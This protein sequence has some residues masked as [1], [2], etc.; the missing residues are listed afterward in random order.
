MLNEDRSSLVAMALATCTRCNGTGVAQE[1][2]CSCVNRGVFRSVMNKFR[3][4]A[5][6]AHHL[7]PRSMERSGPQGKTPAGSKSSEY[8]ADVCIIAKRALTEADFRLFQFHYLQGADWK[9]CCQRLGMSRG[10]FFHVCY[11]TEETLGRVFRELKPYPLYPLDEY[12]QA[13]TRTVDA[14]PFP[15][16]AERYP[17]G[18]PTQPPLAM[19]GPQARP[20]PVPVLCKPEPVRAPVAVT[21]DIRDPAEIAAH[22]RKL[23]HLGKPLCNIAAQLHRLGVPPAYGK[24]EWRPCDVKTILLFAPRPQLRKAA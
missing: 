5:S 22:V 12:F 23:W 15:V 4:C 11:R 24:T 16:P 19:R 7:R 18:T 1:S 14:R 21:W 20:K 8:L 17:N 6:G 9:L 2:V 3:E 10:N 13:F